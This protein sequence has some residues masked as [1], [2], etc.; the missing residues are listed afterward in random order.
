MTLYVVNGLAYGNL[1]FLMA[2]GFT[3]IFGVLRVINM[4]HGSLYLL[5]AHVAISVAQSGAG[6]W[7]GILAGSIVAAAIGS[8][9]ERFLLYR[10]QGDY[11]AQVLVT[12]GLFMIIGDLAL[13]YWGG[14]PRVFTLPPELVYS[15]PV[16]ALR[17]P[18]DRLVLLLVG[19]LI[20]VALWYAIERTRFG[21]TVR[22]SVDDEEI[23]QAIGVSVPRLRLLVFATGS[24][25]AG[26][27]GALGATFVG[28][29]PGLDLEVILLALVIVIIGGP[30]SLVGSYIAALLIGILD[31][32]TIRQTEYQHRLGKR[33]EV[34]DIGRECTDRFQ[35]LQCLIL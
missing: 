33:V 34:V 30:G 4:A 16:G 9:A 25:L 24:L 13:L 1:L 5:G 28:A 23:A 3:L 8:I 14:T 22:A 2:A 10:L 35:Q 19:P 29:K 26:L 11:L 6:I 18:A 20:A 7:A 27:S 12:I 21:A 15:I 17:Y 32:F 31:K